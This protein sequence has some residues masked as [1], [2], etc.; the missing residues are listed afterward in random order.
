MTGFQEISRTK[1]IDTTAQVEPELLDQSFLIWTKAVVDTT[2]ADQGLKNLVILA[3]KGQP[4]HFHIAV[5]CRVN[6]AG[7]RILI[8]G[9][10]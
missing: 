5:R 9:P 8:E 4:G 1:V 3:G 2:L 6:A 7:D 10:S